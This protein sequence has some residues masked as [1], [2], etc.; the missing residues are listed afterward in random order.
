[1]NL[2]SKEELFLKYKYHYYV[3]GESLVE[4]WEF[5]NLEADLRKS[6]SKIPDIVD[7]PTIKEIE[8]LGL[9]P[10][11][12]VD[13]KERNETKYKHPTT[14][15]SL[16]KIQINDETNFPINA[17]TL[18]FNRLFNVGYYEATMKYDGNAIELTYID[19]KLFQGLTRGDKFEGLDKTNK[20]A[21]IVPKTI[22]L[23]GK[24]QIRGEIVIDKE[25]WNKKYNR[26]EPGKVSNPRNYVAGVLGRD[27]YTETELNDLTYVA[28]DIIDYSNEPINIEN[29][30]KVLKENGFNQKYEPIVINFKGLEEFSDLYF[31]LKKYREECP[32]LIDGIVIKYPESFRKKLGCTSHHPKHSIAIKFP[33]EIVSTRI[34]DITWSMGKDGVLCP[35]AILEPVELLGTIVRK[36]TLSNFGNIMRLKAVPGCKCSLKKSG[37]IIPMI[38]AVIEKSPDEEFYIKEMNDFIKSHS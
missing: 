5:D 28:Y 23:K 7:F 2:K 9:N 31:K 18:F 30:M 15:L 34:I 16:E 29:T 13:S 35:K 6:G 10:E 21:Y 20:L 38:I 12:I 36:A 3:K 17:L 32:Y 4:D 22:N 37:E 26:P 25:I 19:G 1:M 8:D 14:Y 24:I 27:I 11:N 33:A